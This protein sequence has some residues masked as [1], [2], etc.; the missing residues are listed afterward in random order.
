MFVL[1]KFHTFFWQNLAFNTLYFYKNKVIM[2]C[3]TNRLVNQLNWLI[4]DIEKM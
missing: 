4:A 3:K 2:V 1:P